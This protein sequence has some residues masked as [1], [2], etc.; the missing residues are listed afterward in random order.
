MSKNDTPLC[1]FRISDSLRSEA[2]GVIQKLK[3]YGHQVTLL[4]GDQSSVVSSVASKLHID[5]WQAEISPD[6]KLDYIRCLQKK[7]DHVLMIGDGI[8]DVP[9]LA[10]ANVSLAMGNASDLAKTSADAVLLS[11]D[12]NRLVDAFEL[13]KKTRQV[14]RQNLG[15]SLTY[16]LTALPLAAAAMIAPWMAAIG[17]SLSSLVVVGNAMRLNRNKAEERQKSLRNNSPQYKAME[18]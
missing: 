11:D 8:N 3:D 4:S 7:G 9:V 15:W 13:M 6:G 1:W 10:G 5:D 17:M 14:I 12:L 16:N 2:A 18:A